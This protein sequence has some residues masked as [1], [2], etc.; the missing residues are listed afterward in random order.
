MHNTKAQTLKFQPVRGKVLT[1]HSGHSV[2]IPERACLSNGAKP[3]QSIICYSRTKLKTNLERIKLISKPI[4]F[5]PTQSS[6]LI[7]SK[8]QNPDTD[9]LTFTLLRIQSKL[10]DMQRSRK[11]WPIISRKISQRKHRMTDIR[12]VAHKNSEIAN[13]N[14][15]KSLKEAFT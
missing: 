11:P 3:A 12:K 9:N 6:T 5:L 8:I 15:F 13:T 14:R 4:N 7:K 1:E 10:P 2:E